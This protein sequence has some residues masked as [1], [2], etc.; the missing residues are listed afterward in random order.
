MKI[1][2]SLANCCERG[3]QLEHS[4]RQRLDASPYV[5]DIR[6]VFDMMA[7]GRAKLTNR[8]RG[9]FWSVELVKDKTTKETF[10]VS[11]PVTSVIADICLQHG[12]AIYPGMKGTV[13]CW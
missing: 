7:G 11:D 4:L 6:C 13:S 12:L 2:S 8:G 9:L 5:G 10:D 1:D 3:D